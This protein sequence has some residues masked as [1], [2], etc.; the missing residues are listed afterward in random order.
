LEV[1]SVDAAQPAEL[2]TIEPAE[3]PS[4]AQAPAVDAGES[5]ETLPVRPKRNANKQVLSASTMLAQKII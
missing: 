4:I 2:D 5:V 3:T 1:S